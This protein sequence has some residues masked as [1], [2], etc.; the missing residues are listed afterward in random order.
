MA[1]LIWNVK[2]VPAAL[3]LVG[4]PFTSTVIFNSHVLLSSARAVVGARH[5]T[6]QRTN[7]M[8]SHCFFM[9]SAS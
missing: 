9:I 8:L 7:T 2:V 5:S 4:S 1:F 3:T 6:I